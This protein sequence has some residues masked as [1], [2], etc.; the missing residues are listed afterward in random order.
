[1]LGSKKVSADQYH[2]TISRAQGLSSLR[3]VFLNSTGDKVLV[4]DWIA[5]SSQIH[6]L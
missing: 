3:S 1:M 6:L 5:G 2:V 4:F